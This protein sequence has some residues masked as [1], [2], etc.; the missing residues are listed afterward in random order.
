[1]NDDVAAVPSDGNH[2]DSRVASD[3]AAENARLKAALAKA[4]QRLAEATDRLSHGLHAVGAGYW[5]LNLGSGRFEVDSYWLQRH[6]E[7]LANDDQTV[8]RDW[9]SWLHPDDVVRAEH[10]LKAHIRGDLPTF[11]TDLR[12]RAPGDQWRWMLVAG[13]TDGLGKDGRW[14]RVVGTF[15]DVTARKEAEEALLKAK[16]AAEA[17]NKAKDQF[18][19]NISHEIRTPMN[20]II[21]MADLVLDSA[22]NSDQRD[23]LR[24]VKSSA[25]SL[26][27]I[28]NDILDFSKIEA[29]KL[30]LEHIDFSLREMMS[31]LAKT[32]ALAAQRN[33]VELFCQVAGDVPEVLRGD[34]GRLRQVLLNLV[35]NAVKFTHEGEVVV[36]TSLVSRSASRARL[37]FAVRDTGIGIPED[38][39]DAIFA[40]FTQADSSTTRKYGGTGLGLAICRQL[41]EL[42]G[43]ELRLV[44][45]PGTGSTFSFVFDIEVVSEFRCVVDPSLARAKVLIVEPNASLGRHLCAQLSAAGLRPVLATQMD[46]AVERLHV[47]RNGV[48]PYAFILLDAALPDDRAFAFAERLAKEGATL[49]RLV[50]LLSSHN[51]N[52][53]IA[54]CDTLGIRARL[55]KPFMPEDVLGALLLARDGPPVEEDCPDFLRFDPKMRVGDP[56][57]ESFSTLNVLLVEDNLVNQTIA[58]RMLERIGCVVTIA[59]DGQEAVDLFECDRFDV[60]FMDMQM[61]VLSGVEAARAIRAREARQSWV[62]SSGN[63]RPVPIVA[64]T[65]HTGE[66]DRLQCMEA[67]MD[68]FVTKPV[69]SETLYEVLRRVTAGDDVSPHDSQEMMLFDEPLA[70]AGHD[71]DLD[72]TLELLDGDVDALQQ[73][74]QIYFRDIGK[75]MSDLRMCR[76]NRDFTRLREMAHSVK[77]SVG[78][79]FAST[80]VDAAATVERLA[81]E[82]DEGVFGSPMTELLTLLDRLS[83]ILRQSWRG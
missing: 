69:R 43:G 5:Q 31:D 67:G 52:E 72:Q 14:Q 56:Q 32:S 75:T 21:G 25:E 62:M 82:G 83:K 35:G 42:M 70:A 47:E 39:Q 7:S 46:A 30:Q 48:D 24:T 9:Q 17:A 66:A 22:L 73:L 8:G 58:Q 1:M 79:F 33:G 36:S 50:M 45:R 64:M 37:E 53:G 19:A 12:V 41:V 55:A 81:R 18:L 16:E 20:G 26:L 15:L 23:C 51:Q 6:G 4:E 2:A 34:P 28:I 40:V 59:N 68:E 80:A 78:V 71:A 49:D 29:G 13:K 74:L 38:R 76:S 44:S 77:G 54:R 65:A 27:V 3:M 11:E 57:G 63:W 60:I 61:P 10:L